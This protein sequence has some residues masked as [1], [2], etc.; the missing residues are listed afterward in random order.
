MLYIITNQKHL[1]KTPDGLRPLGK[2]QQCLAFASAPS[3]S[4]VRRTIMLTGC[5]A[6]KSKTAGHYIG[7]R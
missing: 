7:T 2:A 4:I 6:T 3:Q 1:S 5:F